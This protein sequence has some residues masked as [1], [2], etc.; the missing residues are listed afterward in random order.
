MKTPHSSGING[1]IVIEMDLVGMQDLLIITI[2][3]VTLLVAHMFYTAEKIR[4]AR[5]LGKKL[6]KKNAYYA[7]I[8]KI[9]FKNLPN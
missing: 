2:I 8:A 5:E 7:I 1:I 4:R 3:L 6:Y 9:F